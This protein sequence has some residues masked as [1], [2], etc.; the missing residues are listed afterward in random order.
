MKQLSI[1]LFII[2]IISA[3]SSSALKLVESQLTIS[4]NAEGDDFDGFAN[5]YIDGKFIGTTD[6]RSQTLKV[7][8]KKGEY[9]VIVATE[10]YKPWCS[11]IMLLGKEFRKRSGSPEKIAG[12]NRNS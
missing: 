8:L 10:G 9:T 6:S 5:I 2:I 7:S 12:R 3:C 4:V 11:K 1:L